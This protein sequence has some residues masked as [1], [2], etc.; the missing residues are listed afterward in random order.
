[1]AAL[2]FELFFK[3]LIDKDKKRQNED[4]KTAGKSEHFKCL[5][6]AYHK[7]A[8]ADHVISTG[9]KLNGTILTF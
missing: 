1:M 6:N 5:T 7:S 3:P 8:L 2:P 4:C 9:H